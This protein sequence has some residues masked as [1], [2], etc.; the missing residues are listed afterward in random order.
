MTYVAPMRSLSG[1]G[2]SMGGA[3]GD[4]GTT[5]SPFATLAAQVNR[6]GP[7]APVGLQFAPTP[8]SVTNP[9]L[10]P[11]LA[12]AAVLICQRR[13][14]DAYNQFHDAGSAAAIAAANV[15]LL[16]PSGYVT[17]NLASTTSTVASYADSMGLAGVQTTISVPGIG[18]VPTTTL[19]MVGGAV[20][21]FM[22]L[23]K[24]GRS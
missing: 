18:E 12:L 15:G 14:T 5:V 4:D 16:D 10:D 8:F 3:L 21:A 1:C 17:T 20:L 11:A 6:F 9:V 7:S 13:A 24:R 22:L 19:L 23:R 2:C